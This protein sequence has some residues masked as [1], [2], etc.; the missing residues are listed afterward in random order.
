MMPQYI[1]S[2]FQIS[3][4]IDQLK[5]ISIL[6]DSDEVISIHECHGIVF[7]LEACPN[8]HL[9]DGILKMTFTHQLQKELF[10]A[11]FHDIYIIRIESLLIVLTKNYTKCI[12]S[13]YIQAYRV[14]LILQQRNNDCFFLLIFVHQ[15]F[16][17]Q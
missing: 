2:N 12:S 10:L 17:T 15:Y 5:F 6:L 13:Q 9:I 4:T 11:C 3:F 8:I 7:D 14:H 16:I 1:M